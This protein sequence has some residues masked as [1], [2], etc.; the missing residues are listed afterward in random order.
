MIRRRGAKGRPAGSAVAFF[1]QQRKQRIC[2]KGDTTSLIYS[3]YSI[4]YSKRAK[5]PCTSRSSENVSKPTS[6]A[7]AAQW[8][9]ER[10][11]RQAGASLLAH[12]RRPLASGVRLSA[13]G[14]RRQRVSFRIRTGALWWGSESTCPFNPSPRRCLLCLGVPAGHLAAG[15]ME[16]S[17]DH[18]HLPQHRLMNA[19]YPPAVDH[20]RACVGRIGPRSLAKKGARTGGD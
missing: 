14:R 16:R 9:L 19:N 15:G 11:L 4:Q 13:R 18:A 10:R 2:P 7:R 6:Q 17:H 1:P 8:K 5:E 3:D 20:P 12:A